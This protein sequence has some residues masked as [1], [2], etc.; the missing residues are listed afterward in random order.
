M[1]TYDFY[2]ALIHQGYLPVRV[3]GYNYVDWFLN[4]TPEFK[5]E[6]E[7]EVNSNDLKK[8][9]KY[10]II[11]KPIVDI[12]HINDKHEIEIFEN[13][14]QFLWSCSYSFFVIF[15]EGVH[16]PTLNKTFTGNFLDVS[17]N[18]INTAVEH[19]RSGFSLF[20][21]YREDIFYRL[22]NPE[23]YD[24]NNKF[25]IERTSGIYTAAMTFILLHEF[26]HQYYGH[27]ITPADDEQ[28][29][30][31]EYLADE[32]AFDQMSTHFENEDGQTYKCGILVGLCSLTFIDGSLRGGNRHPD[33][34]DRILNLIEKMNL[35]ELDN[36][37]C[38]AT[39]ALNLWAIEFKK[40][41]K[42]AKQVENY[43]ELFHETFEQLKVQKG[44]R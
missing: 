33:P 18:Y 31:D 29:K 8:S 12:A 3:L 11:R 34:D 35:N 27:V 16:K 36:L 21:S 7:Y 30:K 14:C 4:V 24:D 32:Y 13:Y 40:E 9:I 22:P 43:K 19:F 26:A 41:L 17:N 42:Y 23:K 20:K 1:K 28:S 15:D 2:N 44:S 38:V 37:W 10:N 39:I 25:Y 5:N 6:F